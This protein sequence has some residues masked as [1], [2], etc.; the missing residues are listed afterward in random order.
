MALPAGKKKT[1]IQTKTQTLAHTQ[2]PKKRGKRRAE[3]GAGWRDL[4]KRLA[5]FHNRERSSSALAGDRGIAATYGGRD[6]DLDFL[7]P[8]LLPLRAQGTANAP[9]L[10]EGERRGSESTGCVDDERHEVVA[11]A[12]RVRLGGK[13]VDLG[14]LC[15]WEVGVD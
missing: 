7:Q 3:R 12:R 6:G 14:A 9:R 5:H 13:V 15:H 4:R 11:E 2:F 10:E 1:P 8:D